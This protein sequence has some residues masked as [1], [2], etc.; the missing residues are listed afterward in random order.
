MAASL[1]LELG[2]KAPSPFA[3]TTNP[4]TALESN[5]RGEVRE[6]SVTSTLF[7]DINN[8][9][10]EPRFPSNTLFA[11]KINSLLKYLL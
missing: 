5:A 7:C 6:V 10:S 3:C 4:L 11:I 8:P 1:L 9:K 2:A